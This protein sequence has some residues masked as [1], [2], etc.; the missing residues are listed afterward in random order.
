MSCSQLDMHQL[1]VRLHSVMGPSQRSA[2]GSNPSRHTCRAG[3][4]WS[5]CRRST[6]A[7]QRSSG[8]ATASG[9]SCASGLRRALS[10]VRPAC[11]ALPYGGLVHC[12][13]W[14]A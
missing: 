10:C 13:L 6:R 7:S 12:T 5:C 11:A 4:G 8:A 9:P 1:L 3:S 14:L 2:A